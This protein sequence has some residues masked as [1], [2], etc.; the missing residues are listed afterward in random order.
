[1]AVPTLEV[2]PLPTVCGDFRQL[3]SMTSASAVIHEPRGSGRTGGASL[4]APADSR[5]VGGVLF[6]NNVGYLGMCGHGTIGVVTT[7]AHL[8]RIGSGKHWIETPV[9]VV[10]TVL[11]EDGLG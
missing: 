2:T 11:H 5:C 10:K 1:M 3:A 8:G 9:G 4:S 6:F 7:L